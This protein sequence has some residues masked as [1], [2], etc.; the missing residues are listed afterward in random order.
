[1]Q[2]LISTQ[3]SEAGF[4]R[5]L[6]SDISNWIQKNSD[7]DVN[8]QIRNINEVSNDDLRDFPFH[9]WIV[10]EWNGSFPY[11]FKKLIDESGYPSKLEGNYVML[12]GTSETTFG[13]FIGITHLQHILQW[14]G[15]HVYPKRISVPH[16]SKMKSLEDDTRIIEA[17]KDF[18]K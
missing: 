6:A 15:A 2:I 14:I 10:P 8:V 4:N 12:I 13:N 9:I 11:T 18:I 17:L 7:R 16:L 1:M 5:K 3:S